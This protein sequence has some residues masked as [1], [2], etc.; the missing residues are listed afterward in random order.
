MT[1]Q[2]KV[3]KIRTIKDYPEA[4]NHL[5]VGRVEKVNDSYI[6]T[7]CKTFHFGRVVNN[8]KD[9]VVGEAMIRIIP[10]CRIEIIKELPDSF[11]YSNSKVTIDDEHRVVLS[12]QHYRCKLV[13]VYE[14]R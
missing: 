2:A 13:S 6:K 7:H 8:I 14:K 12:D 10:W 3:W 11:D 1:E 4:H 5:I 9:V